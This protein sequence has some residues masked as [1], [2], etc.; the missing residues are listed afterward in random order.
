VLFDL[1][2]LFKVGVLL[3]LLTLA[4]ATAAFAAPATHSSPAA[5]AL[6]NTECDEELA[7]EDESAA[8]ET[9]AE[10]EATEVV[11][12]EAE[13]LAAEAP[14]GVEAEAP[15]DVEAEAGADAPDEDTGEDQGKDSK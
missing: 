12:P 11:E 10:P 15:A 1:T 3:A 2:K 6:P 7:D 8:D 14:A 5:L 4:C 13:E 9:T